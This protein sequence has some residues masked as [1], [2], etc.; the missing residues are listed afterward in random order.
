MLQIF[1][2]FIFSI[3]A[4]EIFSKM[5]QNTFVNKILFSCL[6]SISFPDQWKMVNIIR[7]I[8]TVLIKQL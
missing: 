5:Q 1:F 2:D 7:V 3:S 6:A 8:I 4:V